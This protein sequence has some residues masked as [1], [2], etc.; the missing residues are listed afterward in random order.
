MVTLLI[1][2]KWKRIWLF[3]DLL[4]QGAHA[5]SQLPNKAAFLISQKGQV[6]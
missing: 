4:K 2:L 3:N 5:P 1:Q 6:S